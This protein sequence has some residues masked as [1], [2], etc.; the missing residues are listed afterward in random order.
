MLDTRSG[1]RCFGVHGRRDAS[2]SE[3]GRRAADVVLALDT[4]SGSAAKPSMEGRMPTLLEQ[5]S[6]MDGRIG[7]AMALMDDALLARSVAAL[8]SGMAARLTLKGAAS[9]SMVGGQAKQ[10]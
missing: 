6:S 4:R 9:S 5:A 7:T 3:H 8:S 10:Q 1:G 2:V